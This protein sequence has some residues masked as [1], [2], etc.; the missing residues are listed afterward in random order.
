MAPETAGALA[1]DRCHQG[2]I[3]GLCI[4]GTG[5]RLS[6]SVGPKHSIRDLSPC[7][8]PFRDAMAETWNRS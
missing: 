8:P 3:S 4:Y 6:V 5:I 7:V 2:I 1:I